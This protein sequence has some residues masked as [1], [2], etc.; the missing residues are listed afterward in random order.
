MS[1]F[2]IYLIKSTVYLGLF[3]AF[4]LVAMRST[5]FFRL[6]RVMLLLGTLVCMLLPYYTLTVEEVEGVQ[7]PMQ[8]LNEKLVLQTIEEPSLDSMMELPVQEVKTSISVPFLPIVLLCIYLLGVFIYLIMVFRSFKEVWKLIATHSKRWEDGCWLVILPDKIPSFSW[9]N[10]IVI[11]E[12]D[13]RNHPQV[14]VHERMHYRFRHSY[15]I[16]FMTLVNAIHWFNP[17]VWLVRTELKQLH[18]FEA[19][20]GVIHQGIDA[21]QYQILLVKKAVGPKLYTIANGF[22]HT[23]L[24][25]RITMMIKE[26]SNGWERLKWLVVVPVTMGAM[27]VFAQPEVKDKLEVITP[28]VNQQNTKTEIASLKKFFAEQLETAENKVRRPDGTVKVRSNT[29]HMLLIQPDSKVILEE[30]ELT[31]NFQQNIQDYLRNARTADK[32]N[33]GKDEPHT[34]YLKYSANVN[35]ELVLQVMSDIKKAYDELRAEYIQQGVQDIES[36]CPYKVYIEGP[37]EYWPG[38]VEITVVSADKTQKE[39]CYEFKYKKFKDLAKRFGRNS[40][41]TFK[42]DKNAKE[43]YSAFTQRHLKSLFDNVEEIKNAE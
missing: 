33:I 31:D 32:K 12:E 41:V 43:W 30:K 21:T 2:L 11:S 7:L 22:N 28:V 13:Y 14:L 26:K 29:V 10:Y 35:D 4:F 42:V 20:R 19:D 1:Y 15:D 23:K 25:K 9:V 3:Y 16:L 36:I 8:V 27:L 40:T 37:Y 34:I 24:K 38:G 6:N 39:V 17:M 5:T 18:E